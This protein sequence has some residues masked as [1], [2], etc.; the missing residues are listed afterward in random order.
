LVKL[1][2]LCIKHSRNMQDIDRLLFQSA[3]TGFHLVECNVDGRNDA[4][5]ARS[6]TIELFIE[7]SMPAC[8][9]DVNVWTFGVNVAMKP[10]AE[11]ASRQLTN[12]LPSSEGDDAMMIDQ[13]C[14]D[15]ATQD[16]GA[17]CS[18][19]GGKGSQSGNGG[20]AKRAKQCC[21]QLLSPCPLVNEGV[22][23]ADFG[24]GVK[25]VVPVVLSADKERSTDVLARCRA[26]GIPM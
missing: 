20:D 21:W 14:A 24:K 23:V 8:D 16:A 17:T 6:T 15:A 10:A 2:N 19:A 1:A 13:R 12:G 18:A 22:I 26:H 7:T 11:C 4:S 5:G 25:V 9:L 3:D